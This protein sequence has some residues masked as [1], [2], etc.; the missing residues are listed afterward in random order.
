M[1]A[2][3][4]RVGWWNWVVSFHDHWKYQLQSMVSLFG[5]VT[6][7]IVQTSITNFLLLTC[8]DVISDNRIAVGIVWRFCFSTT[9]HMLTF[10]TIFVFLIHSH[11]IFCLLQ[12]SPKYLCMY[13]LK[14][15]ILFYLTVVLSNLQTLF[16][17][18]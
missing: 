1:G 16:R 12:T 3:W 11:S 15:R 13:F 9:F 18:H 6:L 8:F 4:R 17:F 2:V 10:F 14:S 5:Q 7:F